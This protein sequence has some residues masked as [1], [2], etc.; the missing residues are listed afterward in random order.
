MEQGETWDDKIGRV[1][2]GGTFDFS[3]LSEDQTTAI[4]KMDPE[5]EDYNDIIRS[6]LQQCRESMDFEEPQHRIQVRSELTDGPIPAASFDYGKFQ[7]SCNWRELYN[8]FWG[9]IQLAS[10]MDVDWVKKQEGLVN[11]LK[12]KMERGELNME[13]M[14]MEVLMGFESSYSGNV[15]K[16]RRARIKRQYKQRDGFDWDE[17]NEDY[18]REEPRILKALAKERQLVS[19]QEFSDDEM[20]D[21]DDDNI[22]SEEQ[23]ENEWEDEEG[24]DEDVEADD[25]HVV[26]S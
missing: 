15:K 8:A 6:R 4:F 19:M 5:H 13:A 20:E 7:L 26:S 14:M 10:S 22:G 25:V 3:H 9:E 1:V 16:A 24:S 18:V 11:G 2:L 23:S 17:N 12:G 21:D